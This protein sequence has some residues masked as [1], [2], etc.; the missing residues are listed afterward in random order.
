MLTLIG[1]WSQSLKSEFGIMRKMFGVT[2]S[3]GR[4]V[5]KKI[6]GFLGTTNRGPPTF[7]ASKLGEGT[8]KLR[9]HHS[10]TEQRHDNMEY[11]PTKDQPPKAGL[12]SI[13]PRTP[14]R[15]EAVPTLVGLPGA[16]HI[17][18]RLFPYPA[19]ISVPQGYNHYLRTGHCKT[20]PW[21]S[22]LRQCSTAP[23]LGPPC[24]SCHS[25]CFAAQSQSLPSTKGP[26]PGELRP[27][28]LLVGLPKDLLLC[29]LR[30][31]LRHLAELQ[32]LC[33]SA[34]SYSPCLTWTSCP[35]PYCDAS[36][37]SP[38]LTLRSCPRPFSYTSSYSPCRAAP[39]PPTLPA[40]A[41]RGRSP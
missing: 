21:E 41:A 33:C 8:A 24:S 29:F 14:L 15:S 18:R 23:R 5:H 16:V 35:R 1:L 32:R 12:S 34:S 11:N 3:T 38:C 40:L 4:E 37:C 25:S 28:S 17:S 30:Q 22:Y 2:A 39:H 7:R 9:P 20:R 19:P 6:M 36:S 13:G 27:A 31:P 26:R 10:H